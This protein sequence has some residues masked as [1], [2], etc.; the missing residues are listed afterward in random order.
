MPDL[1]SLGLLILS[2]VNVSITRGQLTEARAAG[3]KAEA[4]SKKVETMEL[5]VTAAFD[6]VFRME[7]AVFVARRDVCNVA[8]SLADVAD[9]IPRTHEGGAFDAGSLPE[10]DKAFLKEKIA[11]LRKQVRDCS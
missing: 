8:Q 7:Q 9:L 6:N 10:K 3:A 11:A 1:V 4:A 5:R 2:F